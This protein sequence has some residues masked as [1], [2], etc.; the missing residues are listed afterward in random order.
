MSSGLKPIVQAFKN[1]ADLSALQFSPVKLDP[2]T[3][4]VSILPCGADEVAIGFLLN[5]PL[6]K[7]IAEVAVAQGAKVV[8][9]S[10][11]TAG[12]K[13]RSAGSG[14]MKTVTAGAFDAIAMNSG[15]DG[16][17]IPVIIAHGYF[18]T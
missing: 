3:S 15:A 2:S 9:S 11:V 1:E 7:D 17:V 16:D 14:K 12:D 8:C 6:A 4:P 5:G 13:L 18:T 10:D